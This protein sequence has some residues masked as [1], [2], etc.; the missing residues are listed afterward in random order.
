MRV[1]LDDQITDLKIIAQ[2]EEYL[3]QHKKLYDE[4]LKEGD[5][6]RIIATGTT[7]TIKGF[8]SLPGVPK[9]INVAYDGG[10]GC[11]HKPE[12][13]EKIKAI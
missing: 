2:C 6:V 13:L 4:M 8:G 7:G 9:I 1:D 5:R 3:A 12:E 11:N 10:G